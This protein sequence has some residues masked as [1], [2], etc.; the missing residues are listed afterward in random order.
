MDNKIADINF[1]QIFCDVLTKRWSLGV[2]FVHMVLLLVLCEELM[3]DDLLSDDG[4]GSC[5]GQER[6]AKEL[7]LEGQGIRG[8]A[9][10]G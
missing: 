4:R 5:A 7:R 9:L 2:I 10:G 8:H 1:V 6:R 3:L